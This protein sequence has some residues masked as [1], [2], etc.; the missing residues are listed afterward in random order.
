MC[1][2]K[3]TMD[4]VFLASPLHDCANSL[5]HQTAATRRRIEPVADCPSF[6]ESD[7]HHTAEWAVLFIKDPESALVRISPGAFDRRQPRFAVLRSV[8]N[9]D[10]GDEPRNVRILASHHDRVEV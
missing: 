4:A 9:R 5:S 7:C 6:P 10:E 3:E 1:R 2:E 8:R